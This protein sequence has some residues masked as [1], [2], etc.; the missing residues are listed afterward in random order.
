MAGVLRTDE[1]ESYRGNLSRLRAGCAA[2]WI[3]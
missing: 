3:R 2:T 1:L